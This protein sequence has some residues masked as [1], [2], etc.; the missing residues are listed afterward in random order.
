M[1]K[2]NQNEAEEQEKRIK[3]N[4]L[5]ANAV[6]LHNVVDLTRILRD[7]AGEGR[8]IKKETVARLSPYLRRHIS[9]FG[10][11]IVDMSKVPGPLEDGIE[12]AI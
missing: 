5:V 6:T 11:Y 12:I 9:R 3:Y 8:E 10:D 1:C 2:F 7:L 4:D